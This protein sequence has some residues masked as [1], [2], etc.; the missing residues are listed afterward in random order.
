MSARLKTAF[1]NA[2]IFAAG[3]AA[4]SLATWLL[5]RNTWAEPNTLSRWIKVPLSPV[6]GL[7]LPGLILLLF[8]YLSLLAVGI[9]FPKARW[10]SFTATAAA[11]LVWLGSALVHMIAGLIG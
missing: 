3:V 9:A 2:S 4:V 7:P 6:L 10:L 8:A 1:I 5:M 11:M